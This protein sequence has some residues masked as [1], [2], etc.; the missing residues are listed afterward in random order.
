MTNLAYSYCEETSFFDTPYTFEQNFTPSTT[1]DLF[2]ESHDGII[3]QALESTFPFSD[4]ENAFNDIL[5]S[6]SPINNYHAENKTRKRNTSSSSILSLSLG[7]P[8]FFNTTGV[9]KYDHHQIEHFEKFFDFK[10]LSNVGDCNGK[11]NG[12]SSERRNDEVYSEVDDSTNDFQKFDISQLL[13]QFENDHNGNNSRK[14]EEEIISLQL[15][16][17]NY[18]SSNCD[19]FSACSSI[20]I[21]EN[22]KF[23]SKNS[24]SASSQD[25]YMSLVNN[26]A[27]L[28]SSGASK[29]IKKENSKGVVNID[30]MNIVAPNPSLVIDSKTG[31][32][33]LEGITKTKIVQNIDNVQADTKKNPKC[34]HVDHDYCINSGGRENYTVINHSTKVEYAN[35]ASSYNTNTSQKSVYN[36]S[37]NNN[38]KIGFGKLKSNLLNMTKNLPTLLPKKINSPTS[39]YFGNSTP[40]SICHD[41]MRD[42]DEKTDKPTKC[43]SKIS[44]LNWSSHINLNNSDFGKKSFVSLLFNAGTFAKQNLSSKT[45][46]IG[47]Y[48]HN[49]RKRQISNSMACDA[50]LS[51]KKFSSQRLANI[52]G[53]QDG[54]A[55]ITISDNMGKVLVLN[56]KDDTTNV[57]ANIKPDPT[58]YTIYKKSCNQSDSNSN[59]S[60]V[61]ASLFST[62]NDITLPDY[63]VDT[64]TQNYVQAN[65]QQATLQITP[66]HKD[67]AKIVENQKQEEAI[68]KVHPLKV[69]TSLTELKGLFKKFGP[70]KNI[71]IINDAAFITYTNH[72]DATTA[73]RRGKHISGYTKFTVS[74]FCPQDDS[75]HCG[76]KSVT[77]D[78]FQLDSGKNF[79][80]PNNPVPTSSLT[81]ITDDITTISPSKSLHEEPNKTNL[82]HDD[83]SP[84][85]NNKNKPPISNFRY[86]TRHSNINNILICQ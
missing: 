8:T 2:F 57:I 13:M 47:A 61:A 25:S 79:L 3:S 62:W 16:L 54:S 53:K 69:E 20:N 26:D 52:N 44:L 37:F 38:T 58:I 48:N 35:G 18:L 77:S 66:P 31:K 34:N 23:E 46:G 45:E 41:G 39:N 63:N 21:D 67:D 86:A 14:K 19:I 5:L 68:V 85:K 71:E 17:E 6:T 40:G 43:N 83:S 72:R 28:N 49:H 55:I 60:N 42:S 78:S 33:N 11:K 82:S 51:G 32:V 73:I 24:S 27:V 9:N 22:S 12:D 15:D 10:C 81:F 75:T 76:V 56:N 70:I 65:S 64:L 7:S 59:C 4:D 30:K 80:P 84:V 50:T 36:A 1:F 29:S 74:L